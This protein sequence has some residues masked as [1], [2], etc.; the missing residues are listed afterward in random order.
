MTI[1]QYQGHKFQTSC[2]KTKEYA[3]FEKQCKKE[4][5]AQCK[6]A[7]FALNKFKPNH[8]CWTA[9]LEKDG[10]Y[11]Y[12]SLPDVRFWKWYDEVLVRTMAHDKDWS[13]GP[14][15]YCSFDEIGDTATRLHEWRMRQAV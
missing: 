15:N 6:K 1:K 3:D 8:F 10:K 11:V 9:V 4:L 12:V 14:N 13:G 5:R 2:D 7:G